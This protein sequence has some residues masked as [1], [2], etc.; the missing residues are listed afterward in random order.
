ML[1]NFKIASFQFHLTAEQL[2]SLV[3][4][5]RDS[6]LIVREFDDSK[7]LKKRISHGHKR[8]GWTYNPQ[9][10][11]RFPFHSKMNIHPSFSTSRLFEKQSIKTTK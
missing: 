8:R 2:F 3:E 4:I 6:Q 5:Q 11:Q 9:I 10:L 7:L 1:E